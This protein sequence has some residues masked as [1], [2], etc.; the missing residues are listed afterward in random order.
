MKIFWRDIQ[1]ILFLS[2]HNM[3]QKRHNFYHLPIIISESKY[4]FNN[5]MFN[6]FNCVI[7]TLK[8]GHLSLINSSY[9][10]ICFH[11]PR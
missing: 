7:K 6:N 4:F 10:K 8:E 2:V 9:S 3:K 1:Q 11:V 5:K